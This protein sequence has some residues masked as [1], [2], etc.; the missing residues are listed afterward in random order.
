MFTELPSNLSSI[1]EV[2]A[3]VN[4]RIRD[5]RST[6]QGYVQNP[7]IDNVD[8]GSNRIINLAD[9]INDL[10]GVNYRSLKKYQQ[11]PGG[12]APVS[13]G[14]GIITF[15][16]DSDSTGTNIIGKYGIVKQAFTPGKFGFAA[17]TPPT[18]TDTIVDI[19]Y[20]RDNGGTF[21]AAG[22]ATF[23]HLATGNS[24]TTVLMAGGFSFKIGD[25]VR[26]DGIQSGGA[27][28]L[29]LVLAQ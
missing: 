4:Q 24:V 13:S 7:A 9:P 5:I 10:D 14:P 25:L 11:Q 3:A 20:S 23:S 29:V 28:G 6:L 2:L 18:G 16:F 19:M 1:A 22:R 21:S 8:L 15:G 26:L 27:S 12:A 17:V